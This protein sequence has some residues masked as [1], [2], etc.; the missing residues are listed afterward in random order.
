VAEYKPLRDADLEDYNR[1]MEIN[2]TGHLRVCQIVSK[3][4]A[5]QDTRDITTRQGTRSLGRGSI[6]NIASGMSYGVVPG[7]VAYV[8]SKHALLG[9]TKA[10]GKLPCLFDI[11]LNFTQHIYICCIFGCANFGDSIRECS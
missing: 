11:P 4:M 6:V 1:V 3:Q 8:T 9:V 10:A 5:T 2:T 7:R